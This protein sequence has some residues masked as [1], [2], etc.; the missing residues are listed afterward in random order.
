MPAAT[1]KRS[2]APVKLTASQT[3]EVRNQAMKVLDL[4]D[5]HLNTPLDV[6]RTESGGFRVAPS[7]GHESPYAVRRTSSG[8]IVVQEDIADREPYMVRRTASGTITSGLAPANNSGGKRPPAALSG[9]FGADSSGK[10][11][12]YSMTDPDFRE[13]DHFSDEEDD[14]MVTDSEPV[15]DIVKLE[16]RAAANRAS[17]GD[18]HNNFDGDFPE[19]SSSWSSRYLD[20]DARIE[21]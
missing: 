15:V 5:D 16:S 12:R 14:I 19:G 2:S 3:E 20:S 8:A 21:W 9:L 6:R 10:G 1:S 18:N 17:R 4:V 7:M 13:D 11:Q